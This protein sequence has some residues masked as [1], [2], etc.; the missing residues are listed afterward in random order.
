MPGR[1]YG[2]GLGSKGSCDSDGDVAIA[3]AV[4]FVTALLICSCGAACGDATVVRGVAAWVL[5]A[6]SMRV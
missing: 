2:D 6:L 4:A 3:T 1:V 5:K